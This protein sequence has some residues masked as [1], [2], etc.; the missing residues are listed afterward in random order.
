MLAA[1]A[2]PSVSA[3]PVVAQVLPQQE[4]AVL[5]DL[6]LAV[7]GLVPVAPAP[8]PRE[9]GLPALAPPVVGH[10][11]VEPEVP[12]HLRSRQ[13]FS[14]AMARISPSPEKPT[15]ERVPRSR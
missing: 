7:V 11:V 3:L 6:L 13:S 15:Y 4:P 9:P 8:I 12:V 1:A 14:A 5:A 10:L 2:V